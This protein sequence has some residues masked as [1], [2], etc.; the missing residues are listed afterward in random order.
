VWGQLVKK[1]AFVVGA[2]VVAGVT[3]SVTAARA[4]DATWLMN[5]RSG[6]FNTDANWTPATAPGSVTNTGTAFFGTSNTTMLSFSTDTTLGGFTFNAGASNF[7]F[8]NADRLTFNG[9]GIVV[10]GGSATFMNNF[11]LV[12]S[13]TSTAGSATITNNSSASLGFVDTSTAANATITNNGTAQFRDTSMAG[14]A[15]ITNNNILSFL[16]SS[17]AGSATITN[18]SNGFLSFNDTSTAGSATII[19]SSGAAVVFFVS[20]TAGSANITNNFDLTFHDLSTAGDA[21]ITNNLA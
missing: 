8:T 1:T 13:N 2:L 20:S 16:N 10:N 6:D 11:G 9:A 19:N 15:S 7:M 14:S 21:T 3:L 12:F 5:P 17:T 4:Q 18:N